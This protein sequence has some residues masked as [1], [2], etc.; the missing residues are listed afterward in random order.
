[1]WA[2]LH[3]LA[4]PVVIKTPSRKCGGCVEKVARLIPGGLRGCRG[5]PVQHD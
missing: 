5:M 1:V 4:K 2:S 3:D